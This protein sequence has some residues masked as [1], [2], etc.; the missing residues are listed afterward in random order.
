MSK[1]DAMDVRKITGVSSLYTPHD[2]RIL[3]NAYSW[4]VS[5]FQARLASAVEPKVERRVTVVMKTPANCNYA[6]INTA[7]D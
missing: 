1:P 4:M 3:T 2:T 7:S 5:F 6:F